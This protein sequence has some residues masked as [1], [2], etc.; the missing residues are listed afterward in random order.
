MPDKYTMVDIYSLGG[1]DM[2]ATIFIK[3]IEHNLPEI[4]KLIKYF[5]LSNAFNRKVE[6]MSGDEIDILMK[7]M[8]NNG[9]CDSKHMVKYFDEINVPTKPDD[10]NV[11]KWFDELF[12]STKYP[13]WVVLG[14]CVAREE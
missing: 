7:H 13:K 14:K 11:D 8:Y 3:M 10:M 4:E 1:S 5:E 12:T 9:S 6:N 2:E